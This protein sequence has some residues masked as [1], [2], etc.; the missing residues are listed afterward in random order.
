M[1]DPSMQQ[2]FFLEVEDVR[3]A[4]NGFQILAQSQ[5]LKMTRCEWKDASE[6][7]KIATCMRR[8]G[9]LGVLDSPADEPGLA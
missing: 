2:R 1:P 3:S 7:P 5:R 8:G 6:F 9:F 4:G